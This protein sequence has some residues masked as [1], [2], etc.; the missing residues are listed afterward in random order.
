MYDSERFAP[1]SVDRRFR[2]DEPIAVPH[3]DP[4]LDGV[5]REITP[6]L[7]GARDLIEA[8]DALQELTNRRT[9]LQHG[10]GGS[11]SRKAIVTLDAQI[12]AAAQRIVELESHLVVAQGEVLLARA[13]A[14]QDAVDAAF[15]MYNA[16]GESY[17]RAEQQLAAAARAHQQAQQAHEHAAYRA[18]DARSFVTRFANTVGT[19]SGLRERLAAD[20]AKRKQDAAAAAARER[21]AAEE[22]RRAS[23]AAE[24][25]QRVQQ[26]TEDAAEQADRDRAAEGA[27]A[28]DFVTPRRA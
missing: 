8:K 14:A 3:K 5:L 6:S 11:A 27:R 22:A 13:N 2:Q 12:E 21:E 18:N 23:E 4:E 10:A 20:Q 25:A 19:T 28:A 7:S 1:R 15:A 26:A 17:K 16:T 24:E 9:E